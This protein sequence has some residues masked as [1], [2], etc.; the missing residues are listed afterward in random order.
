MTARRPA[1]RP[2]GTPPRIARH[3]RSRKEQRQRN[4]GRTPRRGTHRTTSDLAAAGTHRS[5]NRG[6]LCDSGC[7][8]RVARSRRRPACRLEARHHEPG[9][10]AR[11][12]DHASA[13]RAHVRRGRAQWRRTVR[14]RDADRAANGTGAGDR[15]ALCH[16]AGHGSTRVG[17][18]GCVDRTGARDHV[19]PVRRGHAH[20]RRT[21]RRQHVGRSTR[22]IPHSCAP[23]RSCCSDRP[24]TCWA[25]R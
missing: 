17:G 1:E 2:S 3:D 11:H 6:R 18:C 16:H 22:S 21:R 9:E 23:A 25:T 7:R 15:V 20:G 24:A 8:R 14:A 19:E 12:G 5:R 13:L 10:A 4:R